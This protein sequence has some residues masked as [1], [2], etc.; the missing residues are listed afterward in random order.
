MVRD[1]PRL[2][3]V[4]PARRILRRVLLG[5]GPRRVAR[6]DGVYGGCRCPSL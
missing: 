2:P 6:A 3:I 5:A 1:D 4:S